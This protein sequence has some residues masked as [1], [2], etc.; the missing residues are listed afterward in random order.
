LVLDFDGTDDRVHGQQEGRFFHGYYGDYCFLPRYV[1]CGEQL[2]VSYLQPGNSDA[3][4]HA[5]GV[6]KLLVARLRAAWPKV[7]IIFRGD[8]GFCRWRMLRWGEA[9]QVAYLVGPRG[10]PGIG[11]VEIN[12]RQPEAN[13][14]FAFGFVHGVDFLDRLNFHPGLEAHGIPR[15][16]VEGI[17]QRPQG[18]FYG[19]QDQSTL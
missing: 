10:Q 6:L 12:F 13:G 16:R 14:R 2:L 7:K 17:L 1:F 3:A 8:S 4:R 18:D 11:G 15:D 9:H 5:W 19:G